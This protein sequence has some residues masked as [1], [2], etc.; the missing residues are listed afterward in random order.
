MKFS[1]YRY[2]RPDVQAFESEMKKLLAEFEGAASFEEQ[3]AAMTGIVK[4]RNAFDTQQQIASIRHSIDTNDEFYKAE[5]D[6]FDEQ[7]P[8][9]QEF[10]TDY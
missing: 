7:G 2:E 5:Q 8:V 10:V 4:L 1:E 6:F 9:V 3:D